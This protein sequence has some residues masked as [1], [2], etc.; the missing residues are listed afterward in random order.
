MVP[1]STDRQRT[2]SRE[3]PSNWGRCGGSPF[4]RRT[5]TNP[6]FS[7]VLGPPLSSLRQ[8]TMMRRASATMR[9]VRDAIV[10]VQSD[11]VRWGDIHRQQYLGRTRTYSC[12]KSAL[13][14]CTG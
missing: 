4:R 12:T 5:C 11:V 7:R 9:Q 2:R 3:A 10:T 13:N 6:P 14:D 8:V 1:A